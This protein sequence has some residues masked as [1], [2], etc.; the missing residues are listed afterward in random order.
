MQYL[1]DGV[2]TFSLLILS[3]IIAY[4]YFH[5]THN[6]TNIST[7]YM[8]YVFLV[9]RLTSG[10]VWCV[11]A[12]ICGMLGVNYMF[13]YP[14]FAFNFSLSG[15]P[16]AFIGMLII[17]I[18]TSTLTAHA[19]E[20]SRIK[21][22]REA[23]LNQLNEINKQLIIADSSTQIIELTLNY[24]VSSA[25]ISCI[26]YTEDPIHDQMPVSHLVLPEDEAVFCSAY[27]RAIAH[28]AYVSEKPSGM[29]YGITSTSPDSKCFYLPV[30]SHSHTWGVL[31][32][33][34]NDNPA[35]IKDNLSFF[36]LMIPQMALAFERQ[37]LLDDHQRLAIEAEKEKMRG[38][39]LR[40]ISHDLR[41]PLTSIIGSSAAYLESTSY[42][43]EDEKL[44][45]IT[46]IHEDSNWL[47]HMVENLL[48]VT[49]IVKETAKVIKS[50]ELLEEVI[51]ESVSRIKKRYPNAAICVTVPDEMVLVPM[52]AT[53][54]EQ[55]IM[56]LIENALKYAKASSPIQVK[57]TV[58]SRMVQVDVID[59]GI[60]IAKNTLE[61][62][63]DGYCPNH[64]T[65]IDINKG[66]GIGLSI[67]QTIISA[68]SGTLTARNLEKGAIF[69]F[70]LPLEEDI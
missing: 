4:I 3:T 39:L 64:A 63:F 38:N 15:Y 16:F 25:H 35:F 69:T 9:A 32:F 47:L 53:L 13:T 37:N 33:L 30:I 36:T 46:Q 2:K 17:A 28:L 44:Q 31:G 11:I 29:S 50:S 7:V 60:G 58:Q 19:K 27:E 55:V 51:A 1:K 68:H 70:T 23:C 24:V 54:I 41:T 65:S 42:L 8:L 45:L 67:C 20:Q 56:N 22:L 12:S 40:A 48:S 66:I 18:I 62:L 5:F 57:A 21:A 43:K 52:D 59:D 10:Y 26:F 49:R 14:Y 61:T 6:T 34:A